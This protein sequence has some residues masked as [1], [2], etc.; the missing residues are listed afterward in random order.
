VIVGFVLG[1]LA[2]WCLWR[3]SMHYMVYR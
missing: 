3:V 2:A 1:L